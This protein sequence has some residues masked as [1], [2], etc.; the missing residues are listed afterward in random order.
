MSFVPQPPRLLDCLW[1]T[2]TPRAMRIICVWEVEA[3]RIRAVVTVEAAAAR[4]NNKAM[5]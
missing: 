3:E 1:L 5:A 4:A 2:H